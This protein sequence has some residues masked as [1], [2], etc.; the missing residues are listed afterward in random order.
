MTEE[1]C[2]V[3]AHYKYTWSQTLNWIEHGKKHDFIQIRK[4]FED[5]ADLV[6]GQKSRKFH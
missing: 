4:V 3:C 6:Q 5:F 1:V 2:I